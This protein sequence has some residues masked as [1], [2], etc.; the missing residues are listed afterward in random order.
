MCT[1]EVAHCEISVSS[2]CF[3][4]TFLL[5]AA[6]SNTLHNTWAAFVFYC[7]DQRVSPSPSSNSESL[8]FLTFCDTELLPPLENLNRSLVCRATWIVNGV[9]ANLRKQGISG[10][11]IWEQKKHLA[12]VVCE[13]A[14]SALL[15]SLTSMSCCAHWRIV[16]S[17]S[18]KPQH[19]C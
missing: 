11:R 19:H 9:G 15:A 7:K 13:W 18:K 14:A 6:T 16:Q 10:K 8:G 5:S 1:L 3:G 17:S 4:L 12:A 2:I